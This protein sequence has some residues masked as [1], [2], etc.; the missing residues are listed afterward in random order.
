M[1]KILFTTA[2][3]C[4][5][6]CLFPPLLHSR[7]EA[8]PR[9]GTIVVSATKHRTAL[10]N[11]ST[12]TTVITREEIIAR[13]HKNVVEALRDVA[14]FDIKH[15]GGPGG[16]SMPQMRGLTGRFIVVMIDGVR[17]ND[18]SDANGGAGTIFSHLTTEDIECIE[19]VRGSLSPLYGSN[20]AAGVINI[21][22]RTGSGA[23]DFKL[24]YESGS[25]NSHRLNFQ[26]GIGKKGF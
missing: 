24:S 6:V 16:L 26:G 3:T 2:I 19:V 18:P 20:A 15:S 1:N 17:V 13:G 25:L 10:R 14:G 11:V 21:I 4:I 8:I 12:S 22:T 5:L 9:V 23:G 7:Q